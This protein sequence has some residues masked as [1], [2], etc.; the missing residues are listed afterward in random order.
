MG[1]NKVIVKVYLDSK[2]SG[3]RWKNIIGNVD[4]IKVSVRSMQEVKDRIKELSEKVEEYNITEVDVG[5]PVLNEGCMEF[6]MGNNKNAFKFFVKDKKVVLELYLYNSIT[7]LPTLNINKKKM[8]RICRASRS[9]HIKDWS[10]YTWELE[11]VIGIEYDAMLNGKSIVDSKG[12]IMYQGGIVQGAQERLKEAI[13]SLDKEIHETINIGLQIFDIV[14]MYINTICLVGSIE[15]KREVKQRK[16]QGICSRQSN[17]KVTA[18]K[19]GRKEIEI[20][21]TKDSTKKIV[22]CIGEVCKRQYT[23]RVEEWK[24]RGHWRTYKNGKRVYIEPYDKSPKG[25]EVK[26]KRVKNY[27]L[28]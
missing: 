19:E 14:M 11:D 6:T 25:R 28:K 10:K 23:F 16:D 20:D 26:E 9:A 21:L 13:E 22:K 4:L 18:E 5:H 12:A 7:K 27:T 17:D 24:V 8:T 3:Y 15:R 1:K 2:E